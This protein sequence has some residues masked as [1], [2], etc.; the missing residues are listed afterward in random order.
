MKQPEEILKYIQNEK[1]ISSYKISMLEK[2]QNSTPSKK[3]ILNIE[4]EF[5]SL[6]LESIV[7]EDTADVAAAISIYRNSRALFYQIYDLEEP[8]SYQIDKKKFVESIENKILFINSLGSN[9]MTNRVQEVNLVQSSGLYY[10]L[11]KNISKKNKTSFDFE[12][13]Q[14]DKMNFSEISKLENSTLAKK[15][16]RTQSALYSIGKYLSICVL[17]HYADE[18]MSIETLK[19][20]N[21]SLDSTIENIE[22]HIF[23]FYNDAI[24]DLPAI[25]TG[26]MGENLS[27]SKLHSLQ[28]V[29]DFSAA[30]TKTLKPIQSLSFFSKDG[31][32]IA[33]I[34]PS[35]KKIIKSGAEKDS[36]RNIKNKVF[37][38]LLPYSRIGNEK[39]TLLYKY[40]KSSNINITNL[41]SKNI[42]NIRLS[43]KYDDDFYYKGILLHPMWQLLDIAKSDSVSREI[44]SKLLNL[45]SEEFSD[46]DFNNKETVQ[47]I[48]NSKINFIEIDDGSVILSPKTRSEE[49]GILEIIPFIHEK[50]SEIQR[51]YQNYLEATNE[52]LIE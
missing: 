39:M 17:N 2:N 12:K 4:K 8:K 52:I 47:K 36:E 32:R 44:I 48:N 51:D 37:G 16:A 29:L 11:V 43:T 28:N 40:L 26:T 31:P 3:R 13:R 25:L 49:D 14:I 45:E 30:E 34:M 19:E 50:V 10:D 24:Q 33:N 7:F 15:R 27:I 22:H 21:K 41:F 9:L 46:V 6:P 35:F 1:D 38:V 23:Q 42:S 5:I 18:R 20:M